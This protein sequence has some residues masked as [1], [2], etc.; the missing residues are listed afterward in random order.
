M[1]WEAVGNATQWGR[2]ALLLTPEGQGPS[3]SCSTTSSMCQLTSSTH[4]THCPPQSAV[5][6]QTLERFDTWLTPAHFRVARH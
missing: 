2:A 1:K 4:T 5:S 3:V 6:G